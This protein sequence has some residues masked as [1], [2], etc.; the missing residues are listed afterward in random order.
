MLSGSNRTWSGS[1]TVR[2]G[3]QGF[4][5]CHSHSPFRRIH[6]L[7]THALLLQRL[8]WWPR[9]KRAAESA[10]YLQPHQHVASTARLEAFGMRNSQPSAREP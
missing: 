4:L 8:L 5:A 6:I 2:A 10:P 1:A 9:L 7:Q 3:K